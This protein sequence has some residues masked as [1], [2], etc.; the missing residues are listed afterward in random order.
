MPGLARSV[1][2]P[3]KVPS[4]ARSVPKPLKVPSLAR[5]VP[6]PLISSTLGVARRGSTL[7]KLIVDAWG[8]P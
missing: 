6:K 8:S 5:S 7:Q 2:K 3:L 1:P 4:L